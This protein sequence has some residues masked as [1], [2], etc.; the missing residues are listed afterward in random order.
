M[1]PWPNRLKLVA[2]ARDAGCV[3]A[4]ERGT[5]TIENGKVTLSFT[6]DSDIKDANNKSY[7]AAEAFEALG[8]TCV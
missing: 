4:N 8:M 5:T 3:V 6:V 7:S 1:K 2:Q